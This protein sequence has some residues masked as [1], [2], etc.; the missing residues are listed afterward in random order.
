MGNVIDT[1]NTPII[2]PNQ[3]IRLSERQSQRAECLRLALS[4]TAGRSVPI[5]VVHDLARWLYN[6]EPS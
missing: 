6:G 4:L 3:H 2:T 1:L 5:H